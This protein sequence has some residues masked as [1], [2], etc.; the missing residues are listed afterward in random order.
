MSTFYDRDADTLAITYALDGRQ[1]RFTSRQKVGGENTAVLI[2]NPSEARAIRDKLL[3]M[4]PLP[5]QCAEV[6]PAV[7]SVGELAEFVPAQ[8]VTINIANLTINS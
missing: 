6:E 8:G 4:F 7:T 1:V 2:F 3:A 5:V